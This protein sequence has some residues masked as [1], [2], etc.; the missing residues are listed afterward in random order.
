[1][2]I[3]VHI[4]LNGSGGE[5]RA[6]GRW[7]ADQARVQ[8][9]V[10]QLQLQRLD[11][12]LGAWRIGGPLRAELEHL[13]APGSLWGAKPAASAAVAAAPA[14]ASTSPDK[15]VEPGVPS[16]FAAWTVHVTGQ[17]AGTAPPM[18]VSIRKIGASSTPASPEIAPDMTKVIPIIRRG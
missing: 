2:T 6:Q 14:L 16:A 15:S 7:E 11:A 1:M 17:L 5:L 8:L 9:D 18:S 10:D 3:H 13:P 12:H 4:E